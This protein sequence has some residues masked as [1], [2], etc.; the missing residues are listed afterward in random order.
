MRKISLLVL[1]FVTLGLLSSGCV[2]DATPSEDE[3]STTNNLEGKELSFGQY[4]HLE[5]LDVQPQAIQYDLP[6]Q[7][8]EIS[9]YDDFISKVELNDSAIEKLQENGFV[10]IR[11]PFNPREE[12]ITDMYDTLEDEEVPVFISSD[13]LLHLYH[14]QFDETLQRIEEKEFYDAI[15]ELDHKLLQKS[16]EDYETSS[17]E[18][19][20]AAR[21]NM[22]YFSVALSLLE[23]GVDQ[24]LPSDQD[25]TFKSDPWVGDDEEKFSSEEAERYSF[26]IPKIVKDEVEA[27]L[28]LIK[29]HEGFA[30][31]PT[32][33]YQ[34]DY[35]QYIPRGHYTRSEKLKNYFRAFMWH[36]RMSMLLKGDLIEA[37]DPEQ[38]ARIQTL[39]ASLIASHMEEEVE[40][41]DKWERIYSVT[42]FYVGFSDDLGPYEYIQALNTVMGES[43]NIEE[44][45]VEALTAEL[46]TY[47][48]PEIYGGAGKA[49][50]YVADPEELVKALEETKGFRFMGQRF[51]PDSYMLQ[52]LVYP[53]VDDRFMPKSLDVMALLGSERAY[54]LLEAQGDTAIPG[55]TDQFDMLQDEFNGFN[56][57]DWTKNLYWSWLYSLQPLMK[58]YG[59]GYPTFMQTEAWQDKQLTTCLA[60]WTELR[61]DTIMYAKPTFA[62]FMY[63]LNGEELEEKEDVG[64]VEPVPEVYNRLLSLTRMTNSGLGEMDVLDTYSTNRLDRLEQILER[65]VDI[66]EKELQNVELSEEDYD[67]I[68]SF[69][70]ELEDVIGNVDEKNQKT[71][72]IADVHTDPNSGNV[73]E[74]GVGYVDMIVVAYKVPDGRIILGAGPVMTHYEFEQPMSERLTDEKWREM[75]ETSPT[76]KTEFAV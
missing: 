8:S 27:E 11:N 31:S 72:I 4:Y 20:E 35:S 49:E 66:S 60:S 70:E 37:K 48:S 47:Q 68:E 58:D 57:S 6:L 28:A 10:I 59:T 39:A 7:I 23:P 53:A 2:D 1:F 55:Y 21:R 63:N 30:L 36:G 5:P 74:E 14:I 67:F 34:E 50:I 65:L 15:W 33:S 19:K 32:F 29:S 51:I 16:I 52:N 73:L 12:L 13:S 42:A 9:N 44:L 22:A 45:D 71:T 40:L 56:D 64:Y 75:L 62:G 54:E 3:E 26:E 17:G 24:T 46:A 25:S 43:K 76:P 18:L 61:H 41:M 69:G 38:E